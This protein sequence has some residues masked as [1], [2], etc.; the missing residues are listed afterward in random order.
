LVTFL[1]YAVS[2][3]EQIDDPD[4]RVSTLAGLL[5][6]PLFSGLV[7]GFAFLW[8]VR[9]ALPTRF[10]GILT[11][12]LTTSSTSAMFSYVF[13]STLRVTVL[14][15]TLGS[16][17]GILLHAVLF[18]E[19]LQHVFGGKCE[20]ANEPWRIQLSSA[21]GSPPIPNSFVEFATEVGRGSLGIRKVTA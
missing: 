17:L 16:A 4:F 5:L 10:V 12:M 3:L 6:T 15:W 14:Y 9:V 21:N 11:L 7:V 13:L 8:L 19:S 20:R 2:Q 1:I 18:P